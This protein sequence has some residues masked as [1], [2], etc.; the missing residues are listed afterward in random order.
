MPWENLKNVKLSCGCVSVTQIYDSTRVFG[1]GDG[2]I[3][4]FNNVEHC[5]FKGMFKI[6]KCDLFNSGTTDQKHFLLKFID[7]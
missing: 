1:S 5:L 2:D 6:S 3:R 7:I 4:V